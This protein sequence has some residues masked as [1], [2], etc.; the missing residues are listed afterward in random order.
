MDLSMVRP[1]PLSL[2]AA[3]MLAPKAFTAL[4]FV[5]LFAEP[6]QKIA[7]DWWYEPDAGHGLLLAP[8]AVFLA[9]RA[10]RHPSSHP[11]P[12][13][14]LGILAV[15]VFLRFGGGLAAELFTM[16]IGV[17]LAV[18]ALVVFYSGARQVLHWWLP[19]SLLLLAIPL[20]AIVLNAIALPLQFEA[21][22]MG[23]ALLEWRHIPVLL[24]G[25][26]IHIPG[27]ALFVTEACS[28][29]RSL[30]A[31]IALG[32]LISGLWLKYPVTRILL[33]AL[34]IPVAMLLNGVRVFLTGFLVYYVDPSLGEGFMHMTEGWIIFVVAF[35]LLGGF[36]WALSQ[37]ES[38]S[39][40]GRPA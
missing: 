34:A 22:Q 35:L 21:S 3:E 20:P 26:V 39:L 29:L 6:M 5:L 16:R 14:G 9:W 15:G 18:V 28:G 1:R 31:L 33:V 40:R 36:A 30:A 37:A 13:L 12:Y 4:A 24:D 8:L 38:L 2:P 32:V 7:R 11:Q 19:V 17:F 27:Q 23:A 25:N 10:G